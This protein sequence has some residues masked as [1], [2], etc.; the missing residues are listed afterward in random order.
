VKAR[1]LANQKMVPGED[2]KNYEGDE[3]DDDKRRHDLGTD[4]PYRQEI[5]FPSTS[6]DILDLMLIYYDTALATFIDNVACLVTENCLMIDLPDLFTP[7]TVLDLTRNS[8]EIIERLGGEP[9]H[10]KAKRTTLE[11][12]FEHLTR[13]LERY[14]DRLNPYYIPSSKPEPVTVTRASVPSVYLQKES[15]SRRVSNS[16]VSSPGLSGATNISRSSPRASSGSNIEKDMSQ[17]SVHELTV[18]A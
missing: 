4:I 7:M 6:S 5:E 17:L 16:S 13:I 1:K 14:N 9:E 12:E 3:E 15:S 8:P 2:G 18:Q 10:F 11:S